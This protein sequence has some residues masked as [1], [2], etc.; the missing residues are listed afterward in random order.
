MRIAILGGSG[1]KDDH[2]FEGVPWRSFNTKFSGKPYDYNLNYF[3]SL[4]SLNWRGQVEYQEKDDVIFIPKHGNIKRYGPSRTQYGANL[5][6]AKFLGADVVVATTAVGSLNNA[7]KPEHIV[8]PS[9]YVDESNRNDNLF[10]E[11]IVVHTS[12]RPAF[13]EGLREILYEVAQQ[14]FKDVHHDGRYVCIPGDRFG[15]S[16]EGDKRRNYADI[17]GMTICPEAAIAKQL[18]LEYACVAFC[19][20]TDD[21]ANHEGQ[22]IVVM[23]N[24]S[25]HAPTFFSDVIK[26]VRVYK[27]CS[28]ERELCGNIISGDLSR[29]PNPYLRQIAAGLIEKYKK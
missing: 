26:A 4:L 18:D 12:S 9:S 17:V 2:F 7:I 25:Q 28:L 27:P 11:G 10:G 6:A 5:I 23:N 24:L 19:V 20:D 16:A 1:V 29:I 14:H 3:L 15:T 21:N 22:T 8:I 13:S